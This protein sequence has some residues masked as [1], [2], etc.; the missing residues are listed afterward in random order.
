MFVFLPT[1]YSRLPMPISNERA[2]SNVVL[3][4]DSAAVEVLLLLLPNFHP[5][6]RISFAYPR[7][8]KDAFFPFNCRIDFIAKVFLLLNILRIHRSVNL[9]RTFWE[10]FGFDICKPELAFFALIDWIYCTVLR[11]A[12]KSILLPI[13]NSSFLCLASLSFVLACR[14]LPSSQH[15]KLAGLS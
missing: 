11:I 1:Y 5:F 7:I 15:S 4:L 6:Q 10:I 8:L 14:V 2:G 3:T 9:E 12:R 13:A